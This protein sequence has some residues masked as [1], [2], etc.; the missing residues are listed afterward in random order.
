MY[1]EGEG[2]VREVG[3]MQGHLAPKRSQES[4]SGTSVCHY[5]TSSHCSRW[6]PVCQ[7]LQG[8]SH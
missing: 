6:P 4:V 5:L 2:C 7:T 3:S 1:G 8:M